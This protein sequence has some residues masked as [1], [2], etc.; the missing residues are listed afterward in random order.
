MGGC[1]HPTDPLGGNN[2]EEVDVRAD[3]LAAGHSGF[4]GRGARGTE[5]VVSHD[6]GLKAR[7]DAQKRRVNAKA[8][9]GIVAM[10]SLVTVL[11]APFKWS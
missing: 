5:E 11:G 3:G 1:F 8:V 9:T 6:G 7:L 4:S 10:A 2:R